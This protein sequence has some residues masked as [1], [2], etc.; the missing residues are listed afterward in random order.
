MATSVNKWLVILLF[1]IISS[2]KPSKLFHPF[3]VSVTEVQHNAKEK[4]LEISCKI[5][6]DDLEKTLRKNYSG[7]VDLLHPKDKAAMNSLVTE[8]VRKHLAINI[9]GRPCQLQFIGYEQEEEATWTYFQVKNITTVKKVDVRDD[10]LFEYKKE[11]INLLHVIVNGK[12][13]STKLDNPES[14]VSFQF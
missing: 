9:N 13:K 4:T 8:Y 12:R 2:F 6:T 3:F 11:Q 7:V 10:L 1:F 5:F 14:R